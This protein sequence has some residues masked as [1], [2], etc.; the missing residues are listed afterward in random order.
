MLEAEVTPGPNAAEGL[1]KFK[2]LPHRASN[3]R[4]SGL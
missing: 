4:P 2:N 3:P 1:G